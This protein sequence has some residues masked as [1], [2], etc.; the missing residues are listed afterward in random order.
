MYRVEIGIIDDDLSYFSDVKDP[1]LI[2]AFDTI[3]E[4]ETFYNGLSRAKVFD[5]TECLLNEFRDLHYTDFF[6]I[7]GVYK[8]I[9]KN[10]IHLISEERFYIQEGESNEASRDN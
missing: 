1:D 9:I 6:D 3:K 2:K 4:A 8:R 5:L 7:I 10:R